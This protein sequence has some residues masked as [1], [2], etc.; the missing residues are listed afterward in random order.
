MR[1]IQVSAILL[2]VS[3]VSDAQSSPYIDIRNYG[4][5]GDGKTDNCKSL[6]TAA[7]AC[8]NGTMLIPTGTFAT[9]CGIALP[10]SCS[11]Q[12][13]NIQAS[14]IQIS[15]ATSGA[16]VTVGNPST[17][18]FNQ[19][20]E[21]LT[22]N[23]NGLAN[24]GIFLRWFHGF[25]LRDV[26]VQNALVNSFHFGDPAIHY[27]S[28][29]TYVWSSTAYRASKVPIPIAS[30][31][32][33]LDNATDNMI[34]GSS[35]VGSNTGIRVN[36]GGN[37]F[38]NDHVWAFAPGWMTIGY[39]D[40]GL[41][42]FWDGV[43]AD[44]VKTYGL[45]V[46][47]PGAVTMVRGCRFYNNRGAED[48]KAVGIRIDAASISAT[49]SDNIFYGADDKHRLAQDVSAAHGSQISLSGNQAI[50]TTTLLK[51]VAGFVGKEGQLSGRN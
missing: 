48:N 4:A 23:A 11:M 43:E 45:I 7:A 16:V 35:V 22:I 38:T 33:L 40:N 9:S 5:V 21:G 50:H 19:K 8:V 15:A 27:A 37:I 20:I 41:N 17:Y 29:G 47:R 13:I 28:Y 30:T 42:N 26:W 44:S 3:S 10:V 18:A 34:V 2:L 14:I 49:I 25:T 24:D 32:F 51:A 6:T 46:R 31:G 36:T 12:G 1:I 39:D